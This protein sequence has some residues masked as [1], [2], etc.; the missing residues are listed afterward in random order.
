MVAEGETGFVIGIQTPD[1]LADRLARLILSADLRR[2]MGE[3]GR[4]RVQTRFTVAK[5]A[6]EHERVLSALIDSRT[7]PMLA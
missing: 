3:A 2:Q 7:T 6:Q 1:Q 4:K 5:M